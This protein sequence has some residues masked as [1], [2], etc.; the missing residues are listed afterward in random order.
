[1]Y[2]DDTMFWL[3]DDTK[4]DQTI[5]EL[6]ALDFDLTDEGVVDSFLGINID[7]A[8]DG[9][10]NMSQPALTDTIIETLGLENDSKQH[11]TPA[12]SPPL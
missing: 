10:I 9:T 5:S 12:V 8:E 3:P 7:T 2:V 1:M 11:L 6:K 4:I